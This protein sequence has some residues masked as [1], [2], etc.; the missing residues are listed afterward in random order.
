MPLGEERRGALDVADLAR[1]KPR[2]K[3]A[4]AQK[5]RRHGTQLLV[6]SHQPKRRERTLGGQ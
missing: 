6:H 3:L 4:Q 2:D 5:R 1:A